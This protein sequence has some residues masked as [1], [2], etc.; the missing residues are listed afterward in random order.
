M[1]T[2]CDAT[3]GTSGADQTDERSAL[4]RRARKPVVVDASPPPDIDLRLVDR[5]VTKLEEL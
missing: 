1:T 3:S 5:V 2:P 4:P